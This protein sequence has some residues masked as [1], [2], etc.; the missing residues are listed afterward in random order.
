MA[1]KTIHTA[2][3]LMM[4]MA[5]LYTLYAAITKTYGGLL[6]VSLGLVAIE[7]LVF[8]GNRMECPFTALTKK[9]GDPKGC[10]DSTFFPEKCIRYTFWIFAAIFCLG[11]LILALNYWQ[12]R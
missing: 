6:Y 10:M 5:V 3:Y 12:I 9:Y 7:S 2:V 8:F 1:I 4:V 11:S